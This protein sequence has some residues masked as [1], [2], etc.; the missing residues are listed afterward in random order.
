MAQLIDIL[1]G[2]LAGRW[3]PVPVPVRV[4]RRGPFGSAR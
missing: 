4:L 2:W 1:A 3:R